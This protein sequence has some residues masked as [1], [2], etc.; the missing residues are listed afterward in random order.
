M[1]VREFGGAVG[2]V[3]REGGVETALQVK[4]KYWNESEFNFL[5]RNDSKN[6]PLS[7]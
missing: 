2:E 6:L 5:C 7:S 3:G 1:S 4:G